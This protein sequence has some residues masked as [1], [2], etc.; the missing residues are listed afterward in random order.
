[1]GVLLDFGSQ[2]HA[3]DGVTCEEVGEG[4]PKLVQEQNHQYGGA[5]KENESGDAVLMEVRL[6]VFH[7][8]DQSRSLVP[9][10][11][12]YMRVEEEED[13]EA[14]SEPIKPKRGQ[15]KKKGISSSTG[16]KGTKSFNEWRFE[17]IEGDSRMM[18]RAREFKTWHLEKHME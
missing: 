1:M 4:A 12:A 17:P 2:V 9:H 14:Q 18:T 15:L 10:G 13:V 5:C 3:Y 6:H 7:G 11:E 8:D 16:S